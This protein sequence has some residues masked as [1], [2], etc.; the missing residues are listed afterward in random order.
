MFTPAVRVYV[1]TRCENDEPEEEEEYPEEEYPEDD[2]EPD[3]LLLEGR[4]QGSAA[5]LEQTNPAGQQTPAVPQQ[6]PVV[7]AQQPHEQQ[8]LPLAQR[9]LPFSPG[10]DSEKVSTGSHSA[11]TPAL[12]Y[13]VPV[14]SVAG[15]RSFTS[16]TGGSATDVWISLTAPAATSLRSSANSGTETDPT[17]EDARATS[18]KVSD[19]AA[20][21]IS[22]C[23]AAS[24][25]D[26]LSDA[27]ICMV[28]DSVKAGIVSPDSEA[29]KM[30]NE[31]LSA[32]G[33]SPSPVWAEMLNVGR[34]T[35]TT[36]SSMPRLGCEERPGTAER[37]KGEDVLS[38]T[39][40]SAGTMEGVMVIPE[41]R[42]PDAMAE[43]PAVS[44]RY[45]VAT[46][47]I[48]STPRE[49]RAEEGGVTFGV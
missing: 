43:N 10:Q 1:H 42:R 35:G 41:E 33:S 24:S 28:S 11:P 40:E 9:P 34:P 15:G 29:D 36:E 17:E 38:L 18:A 48:P 5:L 20:A 27:E 4:T 16:L 23:E 14:T 22:T 47:P 49:V 25:N 12:T 21:P 30:E 45:S 26:A 13:P 44:R 2:P 6:T 31:A 19:V 8:V 32:R 7:E 46:K 3:P 37:K 39:G